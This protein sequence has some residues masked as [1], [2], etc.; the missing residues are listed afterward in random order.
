VHDFIA[1]VKLS[2]CYQNDSNKAIEVIYHFP[3][4]EGAAVCGFEAEYEDGSIVKGLVKEKEAAKQEYE[5]AKQT[6]KQANLL[7]SVR[8]D[9]FTLSVGNLPAGH[10]VKINITYVATLEAWDNAAAFILPTSIAPR[11]T[12]TTS[13]VTMAEAQALSPPQSPIKLFG[14]DIGIDATCLSEIKSVTCTTHK[15]DLHVSL[16]GKSCHASFQDISLDRDVVVL[17]EEEKPHQPRAC[18]EVAEDGKTMTG[19]VTFYPQ[20]EFC[21]LK[22][23]FVFVIDRSGSMNG[24]KIMQASDTL[25]LFLRSLPA[26]CTFNIVGF[27]SKYEA[28]F[29]SPQPYNDATLERAS[30]YARGMNANLG[31]TELLSPLQYIFGQPV[32]TGVER[33][34][35]VLTDGQVSNDRKIFDL[36]HQH[37]TGETEVCRLF[38][39]GIGNSVSRH[40][41]SGMARAGHGTSSFVEDCSLDALRGKVIKQLKQSLQPSLDNVSIEWKFSKEEPKQTSTAASAPVKTL[42]GYRSP[43]ID[44]DILNDSEGHLIKMF[45]S[46]NPPIFNKEKYLSYAMFPTGV[47]PESVSVKCATPDGPLEICLNIS[48]DEYFEGSTARKLAAQTAITE[49]EDLPTGRRYNL[50]ADLVG[51]ISKSEALELALV[52]GLASKQTSFIAVLEDSVVDPKAPCETK[53]IP[54]HAPVF[55][56]L[57]VH[58]RRAG[59]ASWARGA[60]PSPFQQKQS[61]NYMARC[62]PAGG[63]CGGHGGG[64]G[65]GHG[66][67]GNLGGGRGFCDHASCFLSMARYT[68]PPSS[69]MSASMPQESGGGGGYPVCGG[70]SLAISKHKYSDDGFL[71]S[72]SD[73][74]LQEK[75]GRVN[76][77]NRNLP[78]PPSSGN[79]PGL[80]TSHHCIG[81]G[82]SRPRSGCGGSRSLRGASN[83]QLQDKVLQ[84]CILQKANG[85]F[86]LDEKLIGAVGLTKEKVDEIMVHLG[87]PDTTVFATVL[88]LVVLR[89]EHAKKRS[90]WELQEQ[91]ALEILAHWPDLADL[92]AKVEAELGQIKRSSHPDP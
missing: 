1:E 17:I 5:Q 9:V 47:K 27:G 74:S 28:L 46:A 45:P 77:N 66:H 70:S 81:G 38:S 3:I 23:D 86:V 22:W 48:S 90:Q 35:F 12:P 64:G 75:Y 18:I 84:L 16:N 88:A 8:R 67:G 79:S 26:E 21:D 63:H 2:Q 41:V 10:F 50:S 85:S 82:A 19:L 13:A 57:M 55:A 20:I 69:G 25:L 7:E 89:L 40:L 71:S 31:G 68:P 80:N 4:Y 76:K 56:D 58:E 14:L 61:P 87:S 83:P 92:M 39:V 60:A 15:Q 52:N 36:I 11:Y 54:Q 37:C 73:K 24:R 43:T 32:L 51:C 65:R 33:E 6:G 91:K 34:I 78:P 49:Y 62:V 53:T 44:D 29:D 72:S 59:S 42:L 30:Q